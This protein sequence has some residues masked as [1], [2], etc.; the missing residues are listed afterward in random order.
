MLLMKVCY[1]LTPK[2]TSDLV[3]KNFWTQND[4]PQIEGAFQKQLT[5]LLH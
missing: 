2:R 4:R 5:N 1:Y 3:E